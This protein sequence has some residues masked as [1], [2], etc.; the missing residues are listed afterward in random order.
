MGFKLPCNSEHKLCVH[1]L[2]CDLKPL[3]L[4]VLIYMIL[5]LLLLLKAGSQYDAGDASVMNVAVL[6][7][8]V[9]LDS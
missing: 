8:L 1:E 9:K 6:F 3:E 5:P 4:K 2:H 7:S